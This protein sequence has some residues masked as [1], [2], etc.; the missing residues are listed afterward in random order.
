MKKAS[1]YRFT[2]VFTIAILLIVLVTLILNIWG[3]RPYYERQKIRSMQEAYREIDDAVKDDEIDEL[4]DILDDYSE[5]ENISIAIYDS[6]TSMVLVSSERDNEY[7]LKRL[8][9][10]LFA[11]RGPVNEETVTQT[12]DYTITRTD[13]DIEFFGY[14]N[15]N[16]IMVLM[17]TPV[18]SMVYAAEQSN[19]FLI[20]AGIAALILGI[21]A[22]VI[23]TGK[24]SRMYKLEL[25][26]ERLQHD[27]D[28][29]EKQNQIQREFVANVSHELKT[30][31]T[32]IRGYAEGLAE[33]MCQDEESRNYYAGIIVDE[34]ERMHQIV[35]QLLMLSKIESGQDELELSEFCLSDMLGDVTASMGILADQ[36]HV[37]IVRDIEEQVNVRADELKIE[38][39]ITN[40]LSNAVHH[41]NDNGRI[42]V[43]LK[44]EGQRV[45]VSVFNTG[46]PIPENELEHIWDKFYKVDKA[47]SGNYGGS[48][49]GLSIVKAVMD[50]HGMPYGVKNHEDGVEFWF[51]LEKK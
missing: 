38:S 31:I 50:A 41:V 6:Y 12:G 20:L 24:V 23:L 26:N 16:R 15:D 3:L 11:G 40:Y 14:C 17:S 8:R 19:H 39:V 47:H 32:V 42:D 5:R 13:T 30:P 44:T 46:N 43:R 10:R 21:I 35:Q 49:I 7:L 28:E 36:K 4:S 48:G 37:D 25:E 27:L 45:Y 34:T 51:E 9:D 33:G 29:K 18:Q 2:A 22:V 1:E